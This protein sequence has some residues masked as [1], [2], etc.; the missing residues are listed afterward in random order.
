[1][2]YDPDI[3]LRWVQDRIEHRILRHHELPDHL[4]AFRPKHSPVTN[5]LEHVGCRVRIN[6]DFKSYFPSIS[7]Q[8]VFGIYRKRFGFGSRAS[9]VLTKITTFGDKNGEV[10]NKPHLCQGFI[11]SPTISNIAALSVDRRV[12]GLAKKYDFAFTRYAD[13]LTLSSKTFSGDVDFLIDA[14]YDIVTD[15][16]FKVN[17]RKTNIKRANRR[18]T[19]TGIVVNEKLNL[20]RHRRRQLRAEVD[21]W[22]SHSHHHRQMILG[23]IAWLNTVS[24]QRAEDLWSKIKAYERGDIKKDR[25]EKKP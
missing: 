18:I 7:P 21:H 14:I 16:G 15:E 17:R 23:H 8:R 2:F 12:A 19:V 4:H 3:N 10:G 22:P 9:L 11:T 6:V 1:M 20:S 13:D 25:L 24:P 5:A